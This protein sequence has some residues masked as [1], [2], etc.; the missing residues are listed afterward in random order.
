M[1]RND[2]HQSEIDEDSTPQSIADTEH[3]LNWNGDLDDPIES[4]DDWEADDESEVKLDNSIDD[5]ES[6]EQGNLS[7]APNV[8]GL[9]P[10]TQRLKI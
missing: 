2:C 5:P 9:I 4:E 10:P 3:W 7:A 8:P 6:T 1:R